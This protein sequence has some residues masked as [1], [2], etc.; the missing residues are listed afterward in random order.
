DSVFVNSGRG[1]INCSGIWVPKHGRAVAEA[2]AARIGPV[3]PLPP[4]D[5]KSALA[6]FTVPGQ[7]DSISA[8]I[9]TDLKENGVHDMTAKYRP[10]LF[11]K[12]RCDYLRPTVIYCESPEAA[13][14]KK[15]FMFPFCTVVQCPQ[16]KLLEKIGP[17]LVCSA[18]TEDKK[19]QRQLLDAEHIDRLNIG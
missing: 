5:P 14:A 16:D 15:E 12:D 18:I 4:E 6:A 11:K 1:C 19:W 10:R 2:I 3:Q 8:M 9:D 13:I 17:T 7:A